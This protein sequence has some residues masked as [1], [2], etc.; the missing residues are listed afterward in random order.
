MTLRESTEWTETVETGW[1]TL[2]G[3]DADRIVAAV[4]NAARP[5]S[6]PQLY[7]DGRA[8]ERIAE[9]LYTMGRR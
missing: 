5:S 2:V 4:G 8:S 7:G 6:H 9:L 3:T 1:N